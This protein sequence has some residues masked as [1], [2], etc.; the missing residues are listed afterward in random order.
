MDDARAAGMAFA[1]ILPFIVVGAVALVVYVV[2]ILIAWVVDHPHMPA[3]A[4]VNI[5]LGWSCIGWVVA[6]A[7][8]L[9]PMAQPGPPYHGPIIDGRRVPPTL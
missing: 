9:V 2:P 5:F 7:W 8:A 4:V 6:L 3:I 1:T